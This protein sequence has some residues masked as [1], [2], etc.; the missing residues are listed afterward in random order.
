MCTGWPGSVHDARVFYQSSIHNKGVN[1]TLYP[2][3]TNDE[4]VSIV[5]LGDSAYPLLTWLM[6]PFPYKGALT[7][8][9][10]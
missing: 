5:I 2:N 8:G 7:E 4:K 10:K 1:G 3:W 6:K 9:Q